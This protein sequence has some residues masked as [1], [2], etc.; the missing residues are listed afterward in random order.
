MHENLEILF[1]AVSAG[2]ILWGGVVWFLKARDGQRE[3]LALLR[4]TSENVE[5]VLREVQYNG[6][7]TVKDM[8]SVLARDVA[9]ERQARRISHPTPHYDMVIK[10]GRITTVHASPEFLWLTGMTAS[11]VDGSGWLRFVS[12]ADRQ[13]VSDA[14]DE[15][16]EREHPMDVRY[17]LLHLS[18]GVQR[19]VRH[20]AEPVKNHLGQVIG[21]VGVI[22]PMDEAPYNG[23]REAQQ[24]AGEGLALP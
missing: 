18:T 19:V 16:Q 14:W 8:V 4:T 15:A 24:P 6:G 1:G 17:T 11:S 12:P 3:R 22:N 7:R 20:F 23:Q 10:E 5:A 9:I 2:A 13:R 21:W